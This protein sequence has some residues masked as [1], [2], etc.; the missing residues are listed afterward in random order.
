MPPKC[1]LLAGATALIVLG[2]ADV[3]FAQTPTKQDDLVFD[4]VS[5]RPHIPGTR[6]GE[7]FS[8]D[9]TTL[10]MTPAIVKELI[11]FAYLSRDFSVAPAFQPIHFALYDLIAKSSMPATTDQQRVM[12]RKVLA[13]RFKFKFHVETKEAPILAL[14]LGPKPKNLVDV[15]EGSQIGVR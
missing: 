11:Q 15:P 6:S 9:P 7:R 12:L 13:E 14:T 5:I 4:A 1:L 3:S 8:S 10:R 2:A